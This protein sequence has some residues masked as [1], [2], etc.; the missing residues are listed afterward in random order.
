[1]NKIFNPKI[2]D[3][4]V[5]Y[6]LLNQADSYF[7]M[8]TPKI[9]PNGSTTY[10]GMAICNLA[11]SY[12][13]TKD[14]KYLNECIRFL[15]CVTGYE[16]WGA[17]HLV[18]V[19][20]SAS[21]I[22]FGMSLA[23]NWLGEYLDENLKKKYLDKIQLQARIMY[24][25]KVKTVGSGWSTNYWQN[26]N[27]I[28]HT[29]LLMASFVVDTV[30]SKKWQEDAL[31]NFDYIYRHLPADGSNY[32]GVSYWRYG[33][34]WLFISAYLIKEQLNINY[35]DIVPY[36]RNT[37]Y[38]RLYL[39]DSKMYRQLNF[40]DCHDKYSSHP[41]FLYYMISDIYDDPYARW[42]ANYIFDN[43]LFEEQ[44][45]SKIKPGILPELW[46]C[47]LFYNEGPIK[48][49]NTMP[50][51]HYFEDL[52]LLAI[53]SSFDADAT[54]YAVKCSY[55]GGRLQ[56]ETS[57]MSLNHMALAHQHPDNLSYILTKGNDY[58]V[59]DDGYNRNIEEYDHNS[60]L[61]DGKLLDVMNKSDCYIENMKYRISQ[62]LDIDNYHGNV[63]G[64]V[65]LDDIYAVTMENTTL[66]PI[67]ADMEEVSRTIITPNLD[68]LIYIDILKSKK[69][70]KY[71]V[72]LNS[73]YK[74]IE[75]ENGDLYN[76]HQNSL[77][78]YVL[79]NEYERRS[80]ERIVK[81]VMTTQEPDN[82]CMV[83][84]NGTSY[85]TTASDT[86]IIEI[87]SFK[88]LNIKKT[89]YGYKINNNAL[90]L[91][92]C[93]KYKTD[94]KALYV[95]EYDNKKYAVVINGSY[96][97]TNKEILRKEIVSNYIVR[98]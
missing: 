79:N 60:I 80:Y 95:F 8:P 67:K 52:G 2:R 36:F 5:L 30:E 44:Y 74:A 85:T 40:G 55:P 88:E 65:T 75:I 83:K 16:V 20:L 92:S 46:L 25:Y 19:D 45:R 93:E 66:Y 76:G 77:Y 22:L 72:I 78:H 9:H 24:E 41:V 3:N 6:Q 43:Y 53:R 33:G 21:F 61:V 34:I 35:F 90:Y 71:E 86:V 50:K 11:L 51:Y 12:L 38:F 64:F 32:E 59:I 62:G 89:K 17:N 23:I 14:S 49:V 82:Y 94:A 27:W 70:H 4:K 98:L 31:K 7:E 42:Y 58:F 29:S 47:Y 39:S 54:T 28:N 26:H 81:S 15:D 87:L 1:M 73:D 48:N 84:L 18:N 69:E 57:K 96:L 37:F 10:M 97:I 68:Y 13:I 56:F 63:N 91:G